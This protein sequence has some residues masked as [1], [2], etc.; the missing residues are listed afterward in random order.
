[1]KILLY[2]FGPYGKFKENVSEKIVEQTAKKFSN[3][4]AV[5]LPVEFDQQSFIETVEKYQPDLIIGTGQHP[6]A[7]KIRIERRAINQLA[8]KTRRPRKIKSSGKRVVFSSLKLKP[9]QG[10]YL[11]YNAGRFV[12]NYSMYVIGQWAQQHNVLY[13]FI[14]FPK[15]L[16][17]KTGIKF[18][19]NALSQFN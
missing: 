6:R 11:S 14:H 2:G 4:S 8:S 18:L 5:I 3:V 19:I 12:C 7:R 15:N 16:E 10:A 1:M 9:G 17:V 13:A